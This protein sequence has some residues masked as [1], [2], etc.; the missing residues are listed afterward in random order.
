MQVRARVVYNGRV[1]GVGFRWS[2]SDVRK[3]FRNTGLVQNLR[4]GTV[5]VMLEGVQ[6]EVKRAMAAIDQRMKGHWIEKSCDLR[7]GEPH[8]SGFSI[9]R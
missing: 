4:D 2:V 3:L 5:E 8:F 1:Q 7:K 6:E 9:V